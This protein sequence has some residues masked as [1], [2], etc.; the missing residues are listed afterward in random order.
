MLR[1]DEI[2]LTPT[3]EEE[4]TSLEPEP[5]YEPEEME[6]D[7]FEDNDLDDLEFPETLNEEDLEGG[8]IL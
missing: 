6:E 4:A 2:D 5:D 7:E 1:I 3:E 8:D